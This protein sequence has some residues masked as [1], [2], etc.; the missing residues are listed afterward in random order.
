MAQIHQLSAPERPAVRDG[1]LMAQV[2][3]GSTD[4]F[5]VLYQR[6][7]AR[8]H[9]LARSV[10]HDRGYSE[11]AVQEAFIAIWRRRDTYRAQDGSVAAW[12]LTVV[13]NR[14]IDAVRHHD[15]HATRR[16]DH[17][18][19]DGHPAPDDV[20]G[21]VAA[22]AETERLRPLLAEIPEAQREVI[23]LAFYGELSHTEI[24]ARLE[25]P[26]GTVKGRMRLGLDKLRDEL[27]RTRG[28]L[29]PVER[30]R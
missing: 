3:A 27:S 16:A 28:R 22:R 24:A 9:Q 25:L 19:L 4:A 18:R 6:Y 26:P 1:E 21:Q 20:A 17:D 5:E 12:L 14:A 13:R 2:Q 8:S 15:R 23:T 29:A 11:D 7:H 30:L 10:C